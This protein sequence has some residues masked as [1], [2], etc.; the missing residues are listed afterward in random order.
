VDSTGWADVLETFLDKY[1]WPTV[2][3]VFLWRGWFVIGSEARE[4]KNIAKRAIETNERLVAAGERL[5]DRRREE[6]PVE[7]DRREASR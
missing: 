2:I 5:A 1:G 3:V 7:D 6:V 4:W